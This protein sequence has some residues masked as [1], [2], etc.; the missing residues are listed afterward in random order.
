MDNITL[1]QDYYCNWCGQ[2]LAS[3]DARCT[4]PGCYGSIL[5]SSTVTVKDIKE[6]NG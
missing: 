5:T 4:T 6:T 3:K 2:K 1:P